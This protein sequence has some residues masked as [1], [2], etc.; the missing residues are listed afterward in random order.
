MWVC[1]AVQCM[2]TLIQFGWFLEAHLSV[3]EYASNFDLQQLQ[4]NYHLPTEIAFFLIR[5]KL[6]NNIK[7]GPPEEGGTARALLYHLVFYRRGTQKGKLPAVRRRAQ[8]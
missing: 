1:P 2:E 4:Q 5:P 8:R 6:T 3:A 7:V